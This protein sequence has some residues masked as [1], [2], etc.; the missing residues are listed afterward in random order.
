RSS[1]GFKLVTRIQDEAHRFALEYHRK[2]REKA[3]ITSILDQIEGIGQ[4]RKVALL[5]HFGSI[6]NIKKASVDEL[7]QVKGMTAKSSEAVY[8]YLNKSL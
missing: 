2:A 5:Q 6:S 7:K 4:K 8:N 1:E 3:V